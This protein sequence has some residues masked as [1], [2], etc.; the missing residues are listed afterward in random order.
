M[1][2][3]KVWK[4]IFIFL[5]RIRSGDGYGMTD[6]LSVYGAACDIS[7]HQR[8]MRNLIPLHASQQVL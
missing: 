5:S 8:L 4:D 3:I 7:L 2:I 6:L 1:D